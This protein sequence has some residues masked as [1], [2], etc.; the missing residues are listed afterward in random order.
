MALGGP[1]TDP[2]AG[3][4]DR[5]QL[6]DRSDVDQRDRDGSRSAV[7]ALSAD[8][9]APGAGLGLSLPGP[10]GS[11]ALREDQFEEAKWG[12]PSGYLDER[13]AR[14]GSAA[15]TAGRGLS[16]MADQVQALRET[17][18]Q[19]ALEL[20]RASEELRFMRSENGIPE[21]VGSPALAGAGP[22]LDGSHAAL[23]GG[24]GGA[25]DR[26]PMALGAGPPAYLEFTA[27][28]Y[29]ATMRGIKGR[30]RRLAVISLTLA[31][32]ISYVLVTLAVFEHDTFSPWWLVLLPVIWLIPLPFFV[33]SF[34]GTHRILHRN[35]FDLPEEP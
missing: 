12:R 33:L 9:A 19:L 6:A 3:S 20:E 7:P 23:T 17:V 11:I 8:P 35:H 18:E 16:G 34:R 15:T 24:D 32:S 26:G 4:T 10:P 22:S 31:V 5:V 29:N 13:L 25:S 28:R 21:P 27:R 14:A 1:Q 2:E 30:R